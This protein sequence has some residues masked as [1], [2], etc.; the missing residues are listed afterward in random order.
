MGAIGALE[1]KV[2][3]QFGHRR[4][5]LLI[6]FSALGHVL[7]AFCT[8]STRSRP[9]LDGLV[10][11]MRLG[12][13]APGSPRCLAPGNPVKRLPGAQQI[14]MDHPDCRMKAEARTALRLSNRSCILRTTTKRPFESAM[15]ALN[16][17]V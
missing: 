7:P 11:S 15:I 1:W 2:V 16:N 13:E 9:H 5:Q 8:G 3:R 12:D 4:T 17:R 14:E 10:P 6:E